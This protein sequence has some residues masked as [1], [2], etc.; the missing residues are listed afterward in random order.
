M[1]VISLT[2]HGFLIL[3]KEIPEFPGQAAEGERGGQHHTED[4]PK[5]W[6]VP[7]GAVRQVGEH[8]HKE[9]NPKQIFIQS[10]IDINS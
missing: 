3:Q 10:P 8:L 9:A 7:R 5:R 6:E 4:G 1:C 2:E